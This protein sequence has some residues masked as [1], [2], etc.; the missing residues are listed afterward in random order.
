MAKNTFK[1]YVFYKPYDVL[2][3]FTKSHPQHV[4]LADYIN[5]DKDVYP[6]GRLDRD[7]EGLLL[8]SNDKAVVN[9]L[10]HPD[11]EKVKCYVVQ[12]EGEIDETSLNKLRNGLILTINK[13]K[14][15]TKNAKVRKLQEIP[16]FPERTPP[17]RFRASIPTCWVE[18]KIVEGKNRQVRKMFAHVGFPVLRLIRT[19]IASY[20]LKGLKPGQLRPIVLE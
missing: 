17:V 2:S 12:V 14:L 6:V 18:I 13:K 15:I 3:Q 11:N 4:T 16:E 7:S 8:L 19:S 10:L 1:S 9:K 5:V 20:N